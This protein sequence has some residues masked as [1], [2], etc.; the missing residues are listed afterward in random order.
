M[1]EQASK[2]LSDIRYQ[3][4]NFFGQLTM[5][6]RITILAAIGVILAGM[7]TLII[8][9]NRE[10]WAP[11]YS[12]LD[13][14]DAAKIVEK[15]QENQI[16][17]LLAPGGRTVMVPPHAVDQARLTLASERVLPG[18]GVGFLDMFGTPVLG[19]TGFQQ[20]VKYRIAQE[21]EL[22]RLIGRINNIKSAKVSLALP[23]KTLFSDSQEK[24]TASVSLE[25]SGGIN[26]SRHQVETIAHLVSSAVEGLD[27]RAVQISDQEGRLLSQGLDDGSLGGK[28]SDHYAYKRRLERELEKAVLDQLEPVIGVERVKVKVA[29]KIQFDRE[30]TKEHQIDPDQTAMLSEQLVNENS[31]GSRS[32]PVGPAGVSSN[33]PEAS[34]REAATVTEFDKQHSTR[35]F[36]VSRK[37]VTRESASGKILGLSVAVLLDHKHP[38]LVDTD[39]KIVGR[40]NI[41][42]DV[43]EKE[44][45][46]NLVKAAIGFTISE[47][48][49]DNV[50][51]ANMSFGKPVEEDQQAQIEETQR[52]RLFVLDIVRYTALG[53]AIL[54]LIMLVIRPMVQRLS[55]KPADLDLL[56]G[57]PATIGELEGEEL[58]IPTEREA[59]I[60]P[61]D[62]II[63]IARQ[64]PLKT[65]SMIR[66]W[67]R[68]K[69]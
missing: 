16:P 61:R 52:Q 1:A 18:S 30:T 28:L 64:D 56:M 38:A 43:A 47:E 29:A 17:F 34:G 8:V 20:Q 12:N 11:L 40:E 66:S 69:K 62:K 53:V 59:G 3:F 21:G 19:E 68:E 55:A 41:P 14:G 36:E 60:P 67:L 27:P 48:R 37:E 26:L 35:N 5:A 6:K 46:T 31:T 33:L 58:E 49:K 2:P 23:Q 24:A 10:T 63:D 50:F 7:V 13:P 22:S 65:A 54:A 42:W 44:E 4:A 51:V 32:I 57:L 45:I 39:G 15:L 25:M 9:S